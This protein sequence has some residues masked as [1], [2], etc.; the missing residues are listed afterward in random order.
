MSAQHV[1]RFAVPVSGANVC[2]S[3]ASRRRSQTCSVSISIACRSRFTGITRVREK[4][5]RKVG[6][7]NSR[8]SKC[9]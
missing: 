5:S 3:V 7:I 4:K 2:G 8:S 6:G 9:V 1:R